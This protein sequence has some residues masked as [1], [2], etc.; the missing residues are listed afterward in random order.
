MLSKEGC[1]LEL[2]LSY[3]ETHTASERPPPAKQ[4]VL[5]ADLRGIP[6]EY[7]QQTEVTPL[8]AIREREEGIH[9]PGRNQQSQGQTG[10][11]ERRPDRHPRG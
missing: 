9:M 6:E 10:E 7:P 4:P 3:S 2:S 8:P 5:L 11:K 1:V